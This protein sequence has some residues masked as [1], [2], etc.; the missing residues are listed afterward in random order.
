MEECGKYNLR[1]GKMQ[2]EEWKKMQN[3]GKKTYPQK[4]LLL[5]EMHLVE[6]IHSVCIT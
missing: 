2:F 4:F 3:C 5:M 6:C 1:N